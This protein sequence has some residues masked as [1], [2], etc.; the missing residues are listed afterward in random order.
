[1]SDWCHAV[2]SI[3]PEQPSMHEGPPDLQVESRDGDH[4]PG[5]AAYLRDWEVLRFQTYEQAYLV[6]VEGDRRL[7][8]AKVRNLILR[9]PYAIPV[10]ESDGVQ[11]HIEPHEILWVQTLQGYFLFVQQPGNLRQPIWRIAAE[12]VAGEHE[13]DFFQRFWQFLDEQQTQI[14][15]C[16][17]L[18]DWLKSLA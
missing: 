18:I 8:I 2:D 15:E 13:Y 16:T 6:Y 3:R 11:H 9:L 10:T 1:M 7:D 14:E 5:F 17:G 12:L 4:R